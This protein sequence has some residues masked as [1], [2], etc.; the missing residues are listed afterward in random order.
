MLKEKLIKIKVDVPLEPVLLLFGA[1]SKD[2]YNLD[3]QY[4]LKILLLR[5]ISVLFCFL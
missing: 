2:Q 4:I 5:Y 3:E 1:I